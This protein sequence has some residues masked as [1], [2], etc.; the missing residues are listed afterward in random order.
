MAAVP[1]AFSSSERSIVGTVERQGRAMA[2]K[3]GGGAYAEVD[4]AAMWVADLS[5]VRGAGA[6]RFAAALR[7]RRW[8]AIE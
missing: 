5:G 2:L 6:F 4:H 1:A 8:S 3:G 7:K